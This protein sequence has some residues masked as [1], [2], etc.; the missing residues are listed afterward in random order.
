MIVKDIMNTEVKT[1]NGNASVQEAAEEMKKFRIGS[2]VVVK[3]SKLTGILTERDILDKVVAE[4]S[5]ASKIKV[6]D[7]MTTE[8]VMV[9]PDK[10]IGEAAEL[11]MEKNIKKLPVIEGNRLVGIV[12][13]TDLCSAE[14]KII[15]QLGA[16]MLLPKKKAVAG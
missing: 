16:L 2:L 7:V 4:A 9:S 13:A 8:V 15:E 14:P 6:K 5:D 11:M 12:T 10:D 1:I 3:N